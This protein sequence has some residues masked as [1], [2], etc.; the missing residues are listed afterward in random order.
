MDSERIKTTWNLKDANNIHLGHG[1][2]IGP[3]VTI[4]AQA[5]VTIGDGTLIGPCVSIVDFDHDLSTPEAIGE[6]GTKKP[7][8]VGRHC[9]IGSN[10]VILK[11]VTM[12]DNCVVGA[13]SV[14]TKSFPN[15]SIIAG[16]PAKLIRRRKYD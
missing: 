4:Y 1:V 13:G 14:V 10:A 7:V 5:S 11:G 12:G 2:T 15:D 9:W 3:F 16:N 8:S 6:V